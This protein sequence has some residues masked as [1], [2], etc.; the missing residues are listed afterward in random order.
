MQE[1]KQNRINAMED[2]EDTIEAEECRI[3]LLSMSICPVLSIFVVLYIVLHMYGSGW[4][5][6]I[7]VRELDVRGLAS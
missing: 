2:M 3:L 5:V 4:E 6:L 7:Y 1:G